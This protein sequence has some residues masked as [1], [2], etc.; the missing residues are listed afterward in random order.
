MKITEIVKDCK[1]YPMTYAVASERNSNTQNWDTISR[2]YW[3]TDFT[4]VKENSGTV[5]YYCF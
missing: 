2:V 3:E 1:V 4:D 5:F